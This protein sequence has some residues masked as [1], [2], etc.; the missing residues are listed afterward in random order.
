MHVFQYT[1]VD[2]FLQETTQLIRGS[3]EAR[4]SPAIHSDVLS[5]I[6]LQAR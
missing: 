6:L 5:K 2:F 1:G 4:N 3:N